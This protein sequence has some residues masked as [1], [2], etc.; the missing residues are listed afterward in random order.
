LIRCFRI[1]E[2]AQKCAPFLFGAISA[3]WWVDLFVCSY[4]SFASPPIEMGAGGRKVTKEKATSGEPLRAPEAAQRCYPSARLSY[5]ALVFARWVAA[6]RLSTWAR[7]IPH[8]RSG[9]VAS[10]L[11][12]G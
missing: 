10:S 1:Y 3:F 9:A 7:E 8:L 12:A 5:M 2:G 6:I 11:R 4:F